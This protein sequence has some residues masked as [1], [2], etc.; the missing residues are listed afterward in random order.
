M[1]AFVDGNWTL[2]SE[3]KPGQGPC[4]LPG[5]P[6][7]Q[8]IIIMTMLEKNTVDVFAPCTKL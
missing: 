2:S 3:Q 7:S 8:I 1:G 5:S 4:S 6:S